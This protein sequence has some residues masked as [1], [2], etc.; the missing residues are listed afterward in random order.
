MMEGAEFSLSSSVEVSSEEESASTSGELG[1][2]PTAARTVFTVFREL[3][4]GC[5]RERKGGREGERERV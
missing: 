5:E 4:C 2:P 1:A 3:G